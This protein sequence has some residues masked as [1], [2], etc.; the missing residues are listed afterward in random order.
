MK[1][2]PTLN[3]FMLTSTGVG[4]PILEIGYPASVEIEYVNI[5]RDCLIVEVDNER[6]EEG[7]EHERKP[8]SFC[9]LL[10]LFH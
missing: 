3:E 6:D 2:L 10:D 9:N 4:T 1:R 5:G 7:G 8:T